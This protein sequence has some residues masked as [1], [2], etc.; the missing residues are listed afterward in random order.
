MEQLHILSC[1]R[2]AELSHHACH[3][4]ETGD[5]EALAHLSEIGGREFARALARAFSNGNGPAALEALRSNP[6]GQIPQPLSGQRSD[7]VMSGYMSCDCATRVGCHSAGCGTGS[8][9]GVTPCCPGGAPDVE[10]SMRA[11]EFV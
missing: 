10:G 11:P 1:W 4:L 7:V 5:R 2:N 9:C 3:Y 8:Q 6:A